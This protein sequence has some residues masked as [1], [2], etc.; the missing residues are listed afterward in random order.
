MKALQVLMIFV[1]AVWLTGCGDQSADNGAEATMPPPAEQATDRAP[2]ADADDG[3]LLDKAIA[4]EHRSDGNRARDQYRH[5]K[6]TLTFFGLEPGMTVVELFPGGGWYTEVL[7]PALGEDGRLIGAQFEASAPPAYRP[8]VVARYQEMLTRPEFAN[9]EMVTLDDSGVLQGVDD[10]SVD[11]VLTFRNVHNWMVAGTFDAVVAEAARV[12]KPGGVFGVV[13]HRAAEGVDPAESARR[14]Y[15]PETYVIERANAAGFVL[16]ARSDINA[17]PNDTKD[18]AR[19]VW[20]L[21]PTLGGDEAERDA[22][23]AIGES[24]RMTLKFVKPADR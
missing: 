6:E 15:V 17:N 23:R 20:E 13:E 7:A 1:A 5:P 14:G 11:R 18:Y 22:R 8:G 9:T 2:A 10:A 3:D 21:P 4:G 16:E 12:L 19:G 24:D